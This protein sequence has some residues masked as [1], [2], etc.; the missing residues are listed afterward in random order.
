MHISCW[1]LS[2]EGP[3]KPIDLFPTSFTTI[4]G[5]STT[6]NANGPKTLENYSGDI[7][8]YSGAPID[9]AMQGMPSGPC[10]IG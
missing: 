2:H 5:P 6:G 8:P 3:P 10:T 9:Q 1:R 4:G 7:G